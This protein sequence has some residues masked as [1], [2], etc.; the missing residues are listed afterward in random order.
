MWQMK[1]ERIFVRESHDFEEARMKL[2]E[3]GFSAGYLNPKN[4]FAI[5]YNRGINA[6]CSVEY[7]NGKIL[8]CFSSSNF[9]TIITKD[10]E[11][12][13]KYFSML[14]DLSRFSSSRKIPISRAHIV[15]EKEADEIIAK[16]R[17]IANEKLK[18]KLPEDD[19]SV[20]FWVW[21]KYSNISES[22]HKILEDIKL[23]RLKKMSY[24]VQFM[25]DCNGSYSQKNPKNE[26]T[27]NKRN[28]RKK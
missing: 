19:A 25:I 14:K 17:N 2:E 7:Y 22:E 20:K 13:P 6:I 4:L 1:G 11:L 15:S 5:Y 23:S 24:D 26:K 10:I 8:F 16:N 12:L 18:F 28:L 21:V 27:L 9:K 3:L